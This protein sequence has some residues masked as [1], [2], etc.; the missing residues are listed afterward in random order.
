M[1]KQFCNCIWE[2]SGEKGTW[3][4]EQ[5]IRE[6]GKLHGEELDNQLLK[7]CKNQDV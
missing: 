5:E 2:Q 7:E 6:R 4:C 1:P 3:T